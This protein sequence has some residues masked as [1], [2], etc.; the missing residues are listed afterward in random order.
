MGTSFWEGIKYDFRKSD[1]VV[2]K[3]ILIN[4][5]VFLA[6]NI[7][8]VF[9]FLL[10]ADSNIIITIIRNL[11]VPANFSSLIF[12]PWTLLTYMFLHE[13]FLHILFNMLWFYWFGS[14][15][16]RHIGNKKI[17]PVYVLGGLAGGII[18]I[19]S[20]NIFPAFENVIDVSYALG[21]SAGV[22]A[23]VVAAATL[24]PNHSIILFIIGP[25]KLK[26]I[27][28][29]SIIL[30]LLS[31]PSSN[32]G[33]HIAHLGGALFGYI[34]I[35]Q[36]QKG[37]DLGRGFNKIMDSIIAIFSKKNTIK[38]KYKNT[39]VKHSS[40]SASKEE[41]IDVILDK[42]AQSGYDSLT[43]EEKDFLFKASKED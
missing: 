27:A 13:D 18:Y 28:I 38:V 25:V 3:I 40:E 43:K 1:N 19:L 31:I 26:Y 15:L 16:Q 20:Y 12:K 10:Q 33:G 4:V 2:I 39:T 9:L 24:L 5:G 8:K 37:N 7:I 35:R 22:L 11:A 14:I 29:F 36:L 41:R 30:D 21:A 32:A 6:I 42:I 23:I 34:Y 17:L